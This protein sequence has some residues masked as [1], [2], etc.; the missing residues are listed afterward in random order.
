MPSSD[1]KLHTR[2]VWSFACPVDTNPHTQIPDL[3]LNP[4]QLDLLI[5]VQVHLSRI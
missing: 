1:L 5:Y 4:Y 3:N 2:K